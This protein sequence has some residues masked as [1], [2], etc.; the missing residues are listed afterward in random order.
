M[1]TSSKL[2]IDRLLHDVE[3]RLA[4]LAGEVGWDEARRREVMDALREAFGFVLLDPN[5]E[6]P[7][8][9]LLDSYA[10]RVAAAWRHAS[11]RSGGS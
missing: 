11:L 5:G 6:S 4:A 10:S 1:Y 7:E 9:R 2:N 8:D 3:G